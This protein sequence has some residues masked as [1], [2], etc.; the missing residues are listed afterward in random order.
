MRHIILITNAES[1]KEFRFLNPL[2]EKEAKEAFIPNNCRIVKNGDVS[3]NLI[4][5]I[6]LINDGIIPLIFDTSEAFVEYTPDKRAGNLVLA[7]SLL[8]T[9]YCQNSLKTK[10]KFSLSKACALQ[11]RLELLQERAIS[12]NELLKDFLDIERN[13]KNPFI[14]T[15]QITLKFEKLKESRSSLL[16]IV[17][18]VESLLGKK[19][20]SVLSEFK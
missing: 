13:R 15:D 12:H 17:S 1:K 3:N 2:T 6:P 16:S 14:I 10:S 11:E 7:V 9:G 18:D 19:E 20:A 5:G 4:L 8:I